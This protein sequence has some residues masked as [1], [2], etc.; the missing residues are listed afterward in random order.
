M[1]VL[2]YLAKQQTVMC[3]AQRELRNQVADRHAVRQQPDW[4]PLVWL[5]LGV[6][7]GMLLGV[8]LGV[9]L[10]GPDGTL[11]DLMLLDWT[12]LDWK[13]QD[14]SLP[15]RDLPDWNLLAWHLP[16]WTLFDWISSHFALHEMGLVW[17]P[18]QR[19]RTGQRAV[20]AAGWVLAGVSHWQRGGQSLGASQKAAV[21]EGD[22]ACLSASHWQGRE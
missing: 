17:A 22:W 1:A 10:G 9:Q 4:K 7:L 16:D 2:Q 15:D 8:L 20:L 11:T 6:L 14:Q 3:A 21:K 13:L 12:L 18:H 19:V 5:L